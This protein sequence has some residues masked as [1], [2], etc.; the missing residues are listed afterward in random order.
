MVVFGCRTSFLVGSSLSIDGCS[1]SSCDFVVLMRRSEFKFLLLCHLVL[2]SKNNSLVIRSF[3][4]STQP[5]MNWS[6]SGEMCPGSFHYSVYIYF[7]Q[8]PLC[9]QQRVENH[10]F[11]Y[12]KRE[13]YQ[14]DEQL[15]NQWTR[16]CSP[17][18]ETELIH[19]QKFVLML[20]LMM[21]HVYQQGMKW[22]IHVIRLSGEIRAVSQDSLKWFQKV[23]KWDWFAVFIVGRE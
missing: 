18:S 16:R 23:R 21:L 10:S 4:L 3:K 19:T 17:Y 22:F 6:C 9:A 12:C 14:R 13:R 1:E 20:K 15:T 8:T 2:Q 7:R 11:H 5:R